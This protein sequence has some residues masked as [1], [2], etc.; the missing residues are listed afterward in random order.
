MLH[1]IRWTSQKIAKYLQL[2][3]S[4]IHR[5]MWPIPPFRYLRLDGQDVRHLLDP[6]FDD[7]DW[8]LIS[9]NS[10]WGGPDINFIL[11]TIFQ[12]PEN[13][14]RDQNLALFLPIGNAGDFSHPEALAYINGQPISS[15]DRHHQEIT[16]P[17]DI[18]DADA[19][20]L[21]LH[22]WTGI[23]SNGQ[24]LSL[25]MGNCALVGIDQ[26]ARE[27]SALAR[28][29]LGTA[30]HLDEHDPIRS[31]LFSA[32][33]KA[34]SYLDT[35]EPLGEGFYESISHANQAL[36]EGIKGSGSP[37][38]INLS[39]V[40]HAHL[41]VAWLWPLAQTRLKAGRTFYTTLHL[42]TQN[43]EY[44]FGQ[45]QA[46]LY[47]FIRQDYP[48]LF[49]IIHEKVKLGQW[50]VLGGMWVEADCNISGGESLVRQLLL[51]RSYFKKCFGKD[52]E[53]LVL[54]LP[55]VF[56]F[57]WSLPQLIK[58][59]GLD[60]FF[61]IKLGWS[62]Y[63]RL[64]YDSF[65]WQGI[66]GT[67]V[68][69]HFSTTR[70]G[71]TGFVS[72]FN[73]KATPAEVLNTWKNFQQKDWGKP[74]KRPPLLMVYGYG[75][76]GGG[77]TEEMLEN[78]EIMEDFP[79]LPQVKF[80]RVGDFF[81]KL[82]SEFGE[83]L[84]V[85]NDELYLEY[86]RGTYTTQARNKRANRKSEF[87]LHDVEFLSSMA[88]LFD[89]SYQYPFDRLQKAWEIVCLNQFHDILPGTSIGEVYEES[90][91]QFGEV[92]ELGEEMKREAFNV[93]SD[94]IQADLLAVNPTSFSIKDLAF[95]TEDVPENKSILQFDGSPV[96]TQKTNNG[97]L[98]AL[99]EMPPY[100][101]IPLKI[102]DQDSISNIESNDLS[103]L[104]VSERLLENK[105]LRVVTN[106]D[107]EI[108]SLFDKILN[109]EMI[110]SG[111]I[112]NR[113][114]AYED[115]PKTPDAWEID[116]YY[117]DKFWLAEPAESIEVI[118][119]GNLRV[120]IEIRKK[121]LN[122]S[123]L[124]HISL[125]HN[126]KRIDFNTTI[127]WRERAILLKVA[128]PV[129]ILSPKASYEIQWGDIQRPTHR[130]TSWDWAKFEVPA[131]K[132]VDLSEG[133]CGVSLLNDCKYGHDIHNNVMRI[134]LL[135]SPSY[136]DP[137]ADLGEHRFTYS[138]LPHGSDWKT[139]T[140][141]EAYALND[142]L[143]IYKPNR[144]HND[145]GKA[146][147]SLIRID[148]PNVIIETIKFA[149][150]NQGLIVRLYESQRKRT[151]FELTTAFRIS[152]AWRTNLLEGNIEELEIGENQL[153]FE[154]KPYQILTFRVIP[155]PNS[156]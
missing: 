146:L 26:Q 57:P 69:S 30:D 123:I 141:R 9:S 70:E 125:A 48:D 111:D 108:V 130:N 65:W 71:D 147:H 75:D 82:E 5:L 27:F 155:E 135:R 132:W 80:G 150:N 7:R 35:R 128:F 86:H 61:T 12:I 28:V 4:Q 41:D 16:L 68:L 11:R 2:V 140:I 56:G 115:R 55:D 131:Q 105:Y 148:Q 38:D 74:G 59:A 107:G 87:L 37:L 93:I 73:S 81:S 83:Q 72:T 64:P 40:G 133:G 137:V 63:N 36:R 136:P 118:E 138:L 49:D 51:G 22:G 151:K 34:M 47:E 121:I 99:G 44:R 53:S 58:E 110:P 95:F 50:E 78:I 24:N 154:I 124:Q 52:A 31:S 134:T 94:N 103:E 45:S 67:R 91:E 101:V 20:H 139:G 6:K 144:N 89:E 129:E 100:S 46:Q 143:L 21:A 85:W 3:E 54:W 29:A 39:A 145:L 92:S 62:Q 10:Y 15:I 98:L 113:F 149:E 8:E 120:A 152:K 32:L 88:V 33:N 14:E 117:E 119:T 106:S 142:P 96:Q 109:Q 60:Y 19:L 112:A 17:I 97:C 43:P 23:L 25:Q 126:S 102:V 79:G 114:I 18:S 156:M 90:L 66:D 1:D 104:Y 77:P 127:D 116:I 76:G 13:W 42:M 153:Q 122:S 84:P